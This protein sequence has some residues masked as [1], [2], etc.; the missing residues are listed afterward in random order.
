MTRK[1]ERACWDTYNDLLQKV[2]AITD[3]WWRTS[4]I[5]ILRIFFCLAIILSMQGC[6]FIFIPGSVVGAVSDTVTGSEGSHCVGANA[7]VG[8]T[9]RL[10]GGGR[11]TIKSLSGTS[12]RCTN[13]EQPIRAL[14][15]F[16]D[17]NTVS[18]KPNSS[19]MASGSGIPS[20]KTATS[21]HSRCVSTNRSSG[22][23][24]RRAG[25]PR[26]PKRLE[27]PGEKP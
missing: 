26:E 4:Q 21:G 16:S 10:P 14:L 27:L 13:P 20:T 19:V 15:A 17:D 23:F 8:D 5:A 18:R 11:G 7:K 1:R 3:N 24:V 2:F 12:I 6:W 9:V 22:H 25:C